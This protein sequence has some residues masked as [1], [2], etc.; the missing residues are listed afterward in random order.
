MY[1]QVW[2]TLKRIKY[3]LIPFSVETPLMIS[4]SSREGFD[5]VLRV[6]VV[7]RNAIVFEKCERVC[8]GSSPSVVYTFDAAS[9][10]HSDVDSFSIESIYIGHMFFKKR[11]F[12]PETINGF[13]HRL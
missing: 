12:Q 11:V 5:R 7:P 9:L 6:V 4:R 3:S 2:Q 8:H 10:R 1:L 13:D